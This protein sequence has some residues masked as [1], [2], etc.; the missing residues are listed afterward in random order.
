[1]I[2]VV[3]K[4]SFGGFQVLHNFSKKFANLILNMLTI[5]AT[6]QLIIK[7]NKLRVNTMIQ[8]FC[9][10][11]CILIIS[12]FGNIIIV[13]ANVEM[14]TSSTPNEDN[15]GMINTLLGV[16]AAIVSIFTATVGYLYKSLRRETIK[17]LDKTIENITNAT[18]ENLIEEVTK[19]VTKEIKNEILAQYIKVINGISDGQNNVERL[20]ISLEN[21]VF[22][23]DSVGRL[24]IRAIEHKINQ[25]ERINEILPKDERKD[26]NNDL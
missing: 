7:L 18:K 26:R 22:K 15:L 21:E 16:L 14:I 8:K 20:K 19:G 1:M 10:L 23:D 12:I 3:T 4:N 5:L 9:L 24:I 11:L 13:E 2:G 17:R 6:Y 25:V